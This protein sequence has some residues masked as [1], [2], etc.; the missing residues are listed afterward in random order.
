M[1]RSLFSFKLRT[2]RLTKFV[3]SG[4]ILQY[5]GVQVNSE[6]IESTKPL[7]E[8]LT[9]KILSLGISGA[10][11]LPPRIRYSYYIPRSMVKSRRAKVHVS[12]SCNLCIGL[13]ED[14]MKFLKIFELVIKTQL[15][16]KPFT[17]KQHKI[18]Y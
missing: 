11:I 3:S 18:C 5:S 14:K 10:N 7:S 8:P 9:L 1:V 4:T 17:P 16:L 13:F 6:K 15:Y 2:H 12:F